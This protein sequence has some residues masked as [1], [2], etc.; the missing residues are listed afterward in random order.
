MSSE[1]F[2]KYTTGINSIVIAVLLTKISIINNLNGGIRLEIYQ[3]TIPTRIINK[4][5]KL[6]G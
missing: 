4:C 5:L 3:T 2:R 1:I 6:Y